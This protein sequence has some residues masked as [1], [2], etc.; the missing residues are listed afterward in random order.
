MKRQWLLAQAWLLLFVLAGCGPHESTPAPPVASRT[1]LVEA[2]QATLTP[3]AVKDQYTLVMNGVPA[4]LYWFSW[5]TPAA[6]GSTPTRDYVG[7]TW[8]EA[9]GEDAPHALLQLFG[10]TPQLDSAWYAAISARTYDAAA[11]RLTLQLRM[12]NTVWYSPPSV[13]VTSRKTVLTVFNHDQAS[14][15]GS[16][17]VQHAPRAE[18]AP[19][20]QDGVYTLTLDS[21][22]PVSSFVTKAPLAK[23]HF[24]PV[25]VI[26]RQWSRRFE[27]AVPRA[28][29]YGN[30][31]SPQLYLMTADA[32]VFQ[33]A[34]GK[35]V[36]TVRLDARPA[37]SS[38]QDVA[39]VVDAS[40]ALFAPD[41]YPYGP[42]CANLE[43]AAWNTAT[44]ADLTYGCLP[45][46]WSG[47]FNDPQVRAQLSV[48]SQALGQ[49]STSADAISPSIA[50]AFRTLY[51]T[52]PDEIKALIL[53][54]DP[55]PTPGLATGLSF[56][57]DSSED[58]SS[59]P[60]VQRVLLELQN[61][62]FTTNI[63][64]GDLSSWAEDGVLLLNS[65]LTIPC[66]PGASS[67]TIGAHIDL[68]KDFTGLL[69]GYIDQN[70]QPMSFILWGASAGQYAAYVKNPRH[71]VLK[72][73]HPSPQA[74]G[75]YFFCKA[76]FTCANGWLK[77]ADRGAVNWNLTTVPN[78]T[79]EAC[80]WGWNST[81]R[82]SYCMEQCTMAACASF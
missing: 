16:A 46:G 82:S 2:G 60:S 7:D 47:F 77:N 36:Y 45:A 30:G 75:Q 33:V 80:V 27:G 67:C 73:G 28:A 38:L 64:N 4:D 21:V 59:V 32:P 3:T 57:L 22:S 62:Q 61:E 14:R 70:A 1:F 23:S 18:L 76:Y 19:T 35:L 66:P 72:G 24:S 25:D 39:L 15:R 37:E 71:T 56:S 65:A 41:E 48:V 58:T 53:G 54:Q 13:A 69:I 20:P 17:F 10:S 63:A 42:G 68:W 34:T 31:R 78:P 6:A 52:S 29:L 50:R 55:A 51:M 11:Q 9:Y 5:E 8:R 79:A 49:Q 40:Q 12:L 26:A 81:T 44:L 74:N 43:T